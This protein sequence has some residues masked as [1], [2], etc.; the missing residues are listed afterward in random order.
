W[1]DASE[2][3]LASALRYITTGSFNG[4]VFNNNID[5]E[6]KLLLNAQKQYEPLNSKLFE[7]KFIG[8]FQEKK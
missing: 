8:M 2:P 7:K 4:R 3:S 1:G 5:M 6:N